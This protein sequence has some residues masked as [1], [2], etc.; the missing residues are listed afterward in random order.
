MGIPI[1]G[2]LQEYELFDTFQFAI[3]WND[4]FCISFLP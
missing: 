1:T 4:F 3:L 2:L